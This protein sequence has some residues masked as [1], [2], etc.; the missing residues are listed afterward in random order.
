MLPQRTFRAAFIRAAAH[1]DRA[2][3]GQAVAL[4]QTAAN[5]VDEIG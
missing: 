3:A 4:R 5:E 1:E 2:W